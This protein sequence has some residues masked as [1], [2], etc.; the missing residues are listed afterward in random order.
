MAEV[1]IG[2]EILLSPIFPNCRGIMKKYPNE[3]SMCLHSL[4]GLSKS[5]LLCIQNFKIL[6]LKTSS[7]Y[8]ILIIRNF[9]FEMEDIDGFLLFQILTKLRN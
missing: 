3:R 5:G 9:P 6:N 1:Y 8:T 4:A 7:R 2:I